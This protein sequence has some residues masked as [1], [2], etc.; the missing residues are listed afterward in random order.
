MSSNCSTS[1]LGPLRVPTLTPLR[2]VNLSPP[3][4]GW[5]A[6]ALLKVRR[7]FAERLSMWCA[8]FAGNAGREPPPEEQPPGDSIWN[9]PALWMLMMLMH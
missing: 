4:Q 9:D 1:V 2:G 3:A 5:I 7:R 6:T 8:R